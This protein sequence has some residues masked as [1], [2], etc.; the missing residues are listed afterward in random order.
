MRRNEIEKRFDSC[1]YVCIDTDE[2][3]INWQDYAGTDY[4]HRYSDDCLAEEDM[5]LPYLVCSII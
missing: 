1:Q 2:V 3:G 4:E 5:L